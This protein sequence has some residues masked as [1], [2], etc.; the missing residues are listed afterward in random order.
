MSEPLIEE[1][2]IQCD[3]VT[4]FDLL[5]DVR[6]ESRWNKAVSVAELRSDDPIRE[7]SKFLTVYRGME[8]EVALTAF[9]RPDHLVVAASSKN[10]DIDTT[11]TFARE[12]GGTRLVVSTDV[13]P[14]GFTSVLAPLLRMMVRREVAKK[15]RD[16]QA[17]HRERIRRLLELIT[18][19]G[20]KPS[21]V[22][23]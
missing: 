1:V 12:S 14:K 16:G 4:A 7:G 17:G 3:P 21:A 8:N 15:Y 6:N 5:A 10:V 2:L 11:C 9:D 18:S 13:R 22:G 20:G 19:P 23:P